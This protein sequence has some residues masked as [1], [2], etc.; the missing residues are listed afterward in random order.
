MPE[1]RILL[2]N[3][4]WYV[5]RGKSEWSVVSVRGQFWSEEGTCDSDSTEFGNSVEEH[6]WLEKDLSEFR[7]RK[8]LAIFHTYYVV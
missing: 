4:F 8:E 7:A 3:F 2:M 5:V 6:Y 1:H